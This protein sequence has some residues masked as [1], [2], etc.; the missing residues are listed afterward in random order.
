MCYIVENVNVRNS[1]HSN[2]YTHL[3]LPSSSSIKVELINRATDERH[4]GRNTNIA[5]WMQKGPWPDRILKAG[6]NFTSQLYHVH[7]NLH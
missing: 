4:C 1:H 6:S 3:C 7:K 2:H 5:N